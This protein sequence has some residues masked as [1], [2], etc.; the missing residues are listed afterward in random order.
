MVFRD[1]LPCD[2]RCNSNKNINGDWQ[3]EMPVNNFDAFLFRFFPHI[4]VLR[5]AVC[6]FHLIFSSTHCSWTTFTI[7]DRSKNA[8]CL[9]MGFRKVHDCTRTTIDCIERRQN[10]KRKNFAFEWC[11]KCTNMLTLFVWTGATHTC[12]RDVFHAATFSKIY[13]CQCVAAQVPTQY[14]R[15]LF[16]LFIWPVCLY[17]AAVDFPQVVF[18]LNESQFEIQ[19]SA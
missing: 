18:L 13:L 7:H 6:F 3:L 4:D 5:R 15:L 1:D 17:V 12:T 9:K 19:M 11:D 10:M 2:E 8:N 16:P 14:F